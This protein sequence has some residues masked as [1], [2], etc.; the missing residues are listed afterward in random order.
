MLKKLILKFIRP[1]PN[2]VFNIRDAQG[3]KLHTRLHLGLS[4]QN[5][6]KFRHNFQDCV[7]G[8]CSCGHDIETITDFFLHCPHYNLPIIRQKGE[9]QNGGN[10]KIKHAKFSDKRTFLTL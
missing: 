8:I 1:D 5:D 6:H 2:S 10:K 7:N 9:S 4:H 3:I